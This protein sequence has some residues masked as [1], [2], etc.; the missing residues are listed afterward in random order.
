MVNKFTQHLS[1]MEPHLWRALYRL[2]NVATPLL[3]RLVA[4]TK[5]LC[6][7]FFCSLTHSCSLYIHLFVS[8]SLTYP[9]SALLGRSRIHDALIRLSLALTLT[10]LYWKSGWSSAF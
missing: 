8:L 5:S 2:P 6:F 4:G 10:Q 7:L 9:H 3:F 1:T